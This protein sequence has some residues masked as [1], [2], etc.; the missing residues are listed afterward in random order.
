M[1]WREPKNHFDD[2]YFCIMDFAGFYKNKK[3]TWKYPNLESAIRPVPHS[4]E[5]PVP[6]FTTLP[7]VEKEQDIPLPD[8]TAR[9]SDDSCNDYEEPPYGPQKFTQSELNDLV[10]D[11]CL[12]K[13][14]SEILASRLQ[15]KNIL[16]LG[17]CNIHPMLTSIILICYTIQ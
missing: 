3:K 8:H 15:E 5:L 10:R 12:S 17:V 7:D 6:I 9:C 14:Q 4:K 13:D 16:D 11:L 1:V 2:C